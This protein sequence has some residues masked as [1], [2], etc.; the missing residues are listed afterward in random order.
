MNWDA[1][2]AISEIIG[3]IAVVVTLIYLAVQVRQSTKSIQSSTLQANTGVWT[4]L[5][6]SLADK[7]VAAAY[8]VGMSGAP[9]IK[10][11]QYTQFFL[12]CRAMFV[13]FENQFYQYRQGTLDEET[14][15]GYARAIST[16]LM[17]MPGFRV[18]WAQSRDVFSPSFVEHIDV[19]IANTPEADVDAMISEWQRIAQQ[20]QVDS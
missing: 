14:Y 19:M 5:F 20:K 6:S 3:A 7:D 8:A 11:I 4:S 12:M 13:A 1:I 18:W 2:S 17:S 9:D 10:P 16:Q 15:L